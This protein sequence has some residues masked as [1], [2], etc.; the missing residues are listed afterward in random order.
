VFNVLGEKVA[1]LIDGVQSAG[2]HT[3]S[4]DGSNLPSGLYFYSLQSG[5]RKIT[6]KMILIR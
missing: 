6:R 5:D 4:F 2:I 1:T 3:V